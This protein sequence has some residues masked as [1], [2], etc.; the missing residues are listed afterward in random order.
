MDVSSTTYTKKSA[1]FTTLADTPGPLTF[2]IRFQNYSETGSNF[3]DA[4][5]ISKN[6]R[7]WAGNIDGDPPSDGAVTPSYTRLPRE[8]GTSGD[9]TDALLINPGYF[10]RHLV[11][12][13]AYFYYRTDLDTIPTL[14][15]GVREG[16]QIV[17]KDY[18]T[19][20]QI[21]V[22]GP[23]VQDG[24]HSVGQIYIGGTSSHVT[25]Q[26]LVVS[27]GSQKGVFAASNQSAF[28][29]NYD[30]IE[31]HHNSTTGLYLNSSGS[32]AN[33]ESHHNGL[34]TTD[35]LDRGGIGVYQSTGVVTISGNYVHGNG[36]NDEDADSEIEIVQ[37]GDSVRI[38]RNYVYDAVHGGIKVSEGGDGSI[39]AYNVMNGYGSTSADIPSACAFAG[40]LL[41]TSKG[42]GIAGIDVV[43]NVVFETETN[44]GSDFAALCILHADT[45][46][47]VFKNNILYN[48]NVY[49]VT[50]A[51]VL[52]SSGFDFDN[53]AYGPGD[54]YWDPADA[55]GGC[56]DSVCGTLEDWQTETGMD[57]DAKDWSG[58]SSV[59]ENNSDEFTQDT[60]FRLKGTGKS[61]EAIDE[62]DAAVLQSWG[63]NADYEGSPVPQPSPPAEALKPDIGAF[64]YTQE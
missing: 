54:W 15:V 31:A 1:D 62:A 49:H 13:Y 20:E 18:V 26:D 14:E 6:K 58:A 61:T 47:V 53:N 24:D 25:I 12:P 28:D 9:P 23:G 37:P 63:L 7:I 45:V 40:I 36:K 34:L 57:S 21:D 3:V 8:I 59:F 35:Y 19:V 38:L 64:E 30:N 11:T 42:P 51:W 29:I 33:C 27:H 43:N 48:N 10:Y 5:S 60:D 44:D 17:D 52:D 55:T 2:Q 32:I 41:S 16:I 22:V 46:D 4:I 39:I 56:T 50:V